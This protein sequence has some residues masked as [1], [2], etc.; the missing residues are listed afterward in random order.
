MRNE[1]IIASVRCAVEI[2]VIE[3]MDMERADVS[4]SAW[5][6]GWPGITVSGEKEQRRDESDEG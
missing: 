5:L 1:G 3:N 6:D 4:S 2:V